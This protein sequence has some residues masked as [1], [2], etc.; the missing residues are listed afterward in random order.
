MLTLALISGLVSG[1][2]CWQ[3]GGEMKCSI[4]GTHP[5]GSRVQRAGGRSGTGPLFQFAPL[6]GVGIG[7]ACSCAA[8]TG[9]KGEVI[10]WNRASTATCTKSTTGGLATTGIA[11][12]DLVVCGSGLP[13]V[14]WDTTGGALGVLVE[15]TFVQSCLQTEDFATSWSKSAD[16]TLTV[17]QA[18]APDNT[19][20][21]DALVFNSGAA[22]ESAVFQS[23]TRTAAKWTDSVYVKGN[24]QSG[25]IDVVQWASVGSLFSMACNYNS[26]TWTRCS[27][28]NT[29]TAVPWYLIIGCEKQGMTSNCTTNPSVYLWGGNATATAYLK[30]Y[31]SATAATTT[32]VAETP[33]FNG[34]T[35]GLPGGPFAVAAAFTSEWDM[36]DQVTPNTFIE[37]QIG[38]AS[39]GMF[40]LVSGF[41]RLQTLN[42][43]S[44]NVSTV[45]S[46]NV[47]KGN[48]FLF[49]ATNNAGGT[50]TLYQAHAVLGGPTATNT[51]ALPWSTTTGI[52]YAPGTAASQIDG[53]ISRLC[54]DTSTGKCPP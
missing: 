46:P 34:Q 53:I 45:P 40:T 13:R 29:L 3:Q 44:A 18:T 51:M 12:G 42:S 16:V 1:Q 39:G 22:S 23:I 10:T 43:G 20:T 7:T 31:L 17:N 41:L 47:S 28:S 50:S 21:A 36:A 11:N 33:S 54:I 49:G 52:G 6:S 2:I 4:E 5:H 15:K 8:V 19:V 24:G 26:T 30:S 25:T 48:T 14:E 38:S 37:G 27:L 32:L 9:S 35:V